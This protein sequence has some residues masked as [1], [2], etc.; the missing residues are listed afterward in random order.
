[1][2]TDLLTSNTCSSFSSSKTEIPSVDYYLHQQP[3]LKSTLQQINSLKTVKASKNTAAADLTCM[4]I[5]FEIAMQ[6]SIPVYPRG[7]VRGIRSSPVYNN[8]RRKETI[9]RKNHDIE[10]VC[11]NCQ[12]KIGIIVNCQTSRLPVMYKYIAFI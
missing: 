2:Q 1:M 12:F 5:R 11:F 6:Y 10:K 7:K 3:S 8:I 4:K 9:L